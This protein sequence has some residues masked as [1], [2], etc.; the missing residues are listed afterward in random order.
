MSK[1]IVAAECSRIWVEHGR[2]DTGL[3]VDEARDLGSPLHPYLEWDDTTGAEAYRH[4]Q[5]GNLIRSVRVQIT[6]HDGEP[7]SVRAY[8]NIPGPHDEDDDEQLAGYV[9]QDVVASSP[10]LSRIALREME[11][12]WKHLRRTYAEYREFWTMV[13]ADEQ[14]TEAA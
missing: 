2:L 13:N 10:E 5:A 6:R 9:P 3:V 8:V 14:V 4:V 1:G 12:R 11:R 7:S